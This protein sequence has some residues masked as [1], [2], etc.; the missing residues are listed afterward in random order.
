VVLCKLI[1]YTLV[2]IVLDIIFFILIWRMYIQNSNYT[3]PLSIIWHPVTNILYLL[4]AALI[5]LCI[6]KPVCKWWLA[7]LFPLKK[8]MLVA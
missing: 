3:Q 4:N 7:L 6:R 1:K 5:P 8:C 2:K